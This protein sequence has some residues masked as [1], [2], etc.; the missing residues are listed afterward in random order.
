M[1]KKPSL[2]VRIGSL[3]SGILL[4]TMP[5]LLAVAADA[6]VRTAEPSASAA[7]YAQG[8]SW[9]QFLAGAKVQ[10]ETWLKNAGREVAP[11]LVE[12]FRRAGDGLRL[13][14]IT[15][16]WCGDSVHSVPYIAQLASRAGVELRVV[17]FRTGKAIMEAH[18]TPDGRASTPTVVLMR[19]DQEVA[20]WV[21]RPASLQWW[22]LGMTG[23]LSD[24]ERL[25]RKMAW[26]EW[27]RGA[28]A[29]AEIVV[30]AEQA[31]TKR[32]AG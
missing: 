15:A 5:A 14:V 4:L 11:G 17:D 9:D 10:R 30:L 28:D 23:Q 1:K 26:Y 32:P 22:F 31:A 18:R 12:R 8:K 13:L 16:D 2:K 21:E 6:P 7:I 27:S 20:A 19:G 25:E 24:E 3:F 29:L